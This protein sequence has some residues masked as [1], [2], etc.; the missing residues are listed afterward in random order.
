M[1]TS[2]FKEIKMKDDETFDELY[3]QL[4]DIVNSNFN[5]GEKIHDNRIVRK[6]LGSFPKRIRPKVTCV[7]KSKTWKP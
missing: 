5:L 7:E 4:N 3:G 6:I 1:L 2:K